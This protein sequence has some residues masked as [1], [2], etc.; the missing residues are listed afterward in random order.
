M[1]RR[2]N[3]P[4]AIGRCPPLDF[5]VA[6]RVAP[7]RWG[8]TAGGDWPAARR[9]VKLVSADNERLARLGEGHMIAS[10]G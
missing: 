5:G 2:R 9:F 7:Q 10:H 1:R 4:T 6:R 8:R 3:S